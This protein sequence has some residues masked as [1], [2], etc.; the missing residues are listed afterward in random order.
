MGGI[1]KVGDG[2]LIT[3]PQLRYDDDKFKI[4]NEEKG[5][6]FWTKEAKS[7][8]K[9]LLQNLMDSNWNRAICRGI[10]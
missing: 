7:F 10:C 8:G 6:T 1:Y 5:E 9:L 3:L 2:H 4:Y